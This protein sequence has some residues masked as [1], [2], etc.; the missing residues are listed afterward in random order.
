MWPEGKNCG[1]KFG[2]SEHMCILET[3]L[4]CWFV[5]AVV[6]CLFAILANR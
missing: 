3:F 4:V 5:V 1:G 6:G 2:E